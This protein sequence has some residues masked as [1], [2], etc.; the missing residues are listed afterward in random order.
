MP[1]ITSPPKTEVEPV[2]EILHGTTVT[3]PYRWLEDRDSPR[4]RKWIDEQ[5]KY[6]RAY[7]DAAPERNRI[8]RRV[9]E[10]LSVEVI[11]Q[12]WKVG[13][14]VFF[15]KRAARQQQASIVMRAGQSEEDV[16]LVDPSLRADCGATSVN[17]VNV[18]RDA[19]ILAYGVRRGGTD[20]QSVEFLEVKSKRV[21]PDSLPQGYG[22]GLVFSTNGDGFYYVHEVTGSPRP[23]VPAVYWHKFGDNPDHNE[24][25]LLAEETG[26]A[27]LSLGGSPDGSLLTALAIKSNDPLQFDL[28]LCAPQKGNQFRKVLEDIRSLWGLSFAGHTLV[29]LTSLNAPN[30]RIVA[31][32][33]E[34]PQ[35]EH[36]INIVQES[37]QPIKDFTVVRDCVCVL[38]EDKFSTRIE[39]FDLAG[40]RKAVIQCPENGATTLLR[41]TGES[42][43]LFYRVVSFT[44]PGT[45]YFYSLPDSKQAVW[46]KNRVAFDPSSVEIKRTSYK[47]TDGTEVPIFLLSQGQENS[48]HT[49]P[50]PVFLTGY[51]GFGAT[52]TPQY[53]AFFAFLVERG[54]L[55]ALANVRGGGEF[56]ED[57]Y[58]AGKRH[59]RQN[60]I[61]D[62]IAAAEWLVQQ[63]EATAAKMAIGGASNAGLLV[64][65]ALTQ[66]PDLFQAVLCIG[67]FLD[68]LRYDLF[69]SASRYIEEYGSARIAEDFRH[70]L[71]YSPY[72]H[73]KAG[74]SYPAVMIV[75]GDADT[76]CN[77]MHA[78]KMVAHLQAATRSE[79]PVLLHYQEAWG[80]F[81]A[82]PVHR[83]IEMV[84]DRLTFIFRELGVSA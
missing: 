52:F 65:A 13:N 26:S 70:L 10:L 59:N 29:G 72:H 27:H 18:S 79:C 15:L 75:S 9:E 55:L 57:W 24:P 60:A 22:P 39:V 33:P 61:N 41:G 82:Q 34:H 47:S 35:Q 68:M 38:Y 63:G 19:G 84:T 51:G 81:P 28:Y 31:I 48:A 6:T 1:T 14:R 56:G 77:P 71:A 66:R 76:R 23:Y 8:R 54:F 25:V 43:M 3:D 74:E 20:T 37:T 53:S 16:V 73:I 50:R 69:D 21:L 64:G 17:I 45:I 49:K 32:A 12:P 11:S 83:K 78:R 30:R 46:N 36:W 5:A 2:T 42:D 58:R 62:F 44:E 40:R 80:H 7:F 67:P 4:T